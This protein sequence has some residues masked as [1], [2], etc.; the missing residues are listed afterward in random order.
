MADMIRIKNTAIDGGNWVDFNG[1]TFEPNYGRRTNVPPVDGQFSGTDYIIAKGD[2]VGVE[3]P[4]ISVQGSISTTQFSTLSDL[5]SSTPS[6]ITSTGEDG[7]SQTGKITLGYLL[8][9]YRNMTGQTYLEINFGDPSNQTQWKTYDGT[10]T[11]IPVEIIS[12]SPK[13]RSDSQGGHFIDVSIE[14]KEVRV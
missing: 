5:W 13:P 6:T 2:R 11:T 12:I 7:V 9:L 10:T 14:C 8:A 4:I 3:N 1:A